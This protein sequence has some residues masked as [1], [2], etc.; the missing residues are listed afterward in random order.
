MY[1]NP[2]YTVIYISYNIVEQKTAGISIGH[3]T[4]QTPTDALDRRRIA[5]TFFLRH[6]YDISS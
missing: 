6:L 3:S 4:D 1:F 2:L 5:Y